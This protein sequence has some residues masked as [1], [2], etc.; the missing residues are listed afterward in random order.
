MYKKYLCGL[1]LLTFDLQLKM[2]CSAWAQYLS[3]N[4]EK[5]GE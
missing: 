3:Q 5:K 4:N 2:A 1:W